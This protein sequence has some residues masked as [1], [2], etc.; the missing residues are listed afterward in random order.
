MGGQNEKSTILEKD[1]S[2][3][4]NERFIVELNLA[5]LRNVPLETRREE[6]KKPLFLTRYE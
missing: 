5:D 1:L 2:S 6:A 3:N 4:K